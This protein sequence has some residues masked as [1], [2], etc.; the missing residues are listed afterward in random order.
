M[1]RVANYINFDRLKGVFV[2]CCADKRCLLHMDQTPM[3]VDP[4]EE[5]IRIDL[6]LV[7][8][9]LEVGLIYQGRRAQFEGVYCTVYGLT[10]AQYGYHQVLPIRK[11]LRHALVALP[12]LGNCPYD[13]G[14]KIML[15]HDSSALM[16]LG[17]I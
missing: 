17:E 8:D 14:T 9:N 6:R 13:K 3:L 1:N 15:T 2:E 10:R 11:T 7:G 12:N 5:L 16:Q 4:R